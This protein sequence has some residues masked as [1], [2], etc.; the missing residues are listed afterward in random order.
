M[1]PTGHKLVG[2]FHARRKVV[3]IPHN[4]LYSGRINNLRR[5]HG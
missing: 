2:L 3:D 4:T 1:S 5:F